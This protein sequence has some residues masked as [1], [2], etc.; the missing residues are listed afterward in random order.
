ME[1]DE[2]DSEMKEKAKKE[3][4]A[5]ED[6][7]KEERRTEE[8]AK[9]AVE[10]EKKG[11]EE[12]E[13]S[14][15]PK[16]KGR[17]TTAEAWKLHRAN[18]TGD[19]SDIRDW[20]KCDGKRRGGGL[21]DARENKV[22]VISK[23][24]ERKK[25][26]LEIMITQGFSKIIERLD[27]KK[28]DRRK[29]FK[30]LKTELSKIER[31]NAELEKK[32][33]R[34]EAENTAERTAS[35]VKWKE[36]EG[37]I[38]ESEKKM[39]K[40]MAN[41]KEEMREIK[42]KMIAEVGEENGVRASTSTYVPRT[43]EG[44]RIAEIEAW[45]E[46]KEKME[47]RNN[48]VI[49][50][51]NNKGKAERKE[52]AEFFRDELGMESIEES[53]EEVR[54]PGPDK[55]ML[56]VK[57]RRPEDKKKIMERKAKLKGKKIFI[58]NDRTKKEREEQK[59]L[60]RRA[61]VA[62]NVDEWLAEE[63]EESELIIGGDWNVRIGR[64]ASVE[65]INNRE[66]R[67]S[68]DT[69]VNR[70]RMGWIVLNGN[71]GVKEEGRWTFARGDCRTVVDY[72]VTNAKTWNEIK[73]IEIG[74]RL[75]SDHQP[76]LVELEGTR[77]SINKRKQKRREETKWVQSWKEEDVYKFEKGEEETVWKETEGEDK[78][79]ELKR[80][81]DECCVK[82]KVRVG[83]KGKEG[84]YDEQCRKLKKKLQKGGR[85]KRYAVTM[86]KLRTK[87]RDLKKRKRI[88]WE[89]KMEKELKEIK[90]ESDAWE[91]IRK[92]MR[93]RSEITNAFRIEAPPGF[94]NTVPGTGTR[95]ELNIYRERESGGR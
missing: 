10:K 71:K 65:E 66:K 42:E 45:K 92:D 54:Q 39:D 27:E 31:K 37:K 67:W 59:G 30:E 19:L 16:G 57:M 41:I 6:E 77:E 38:E 76:V 4:E 83:E 93:I 47:R 70:E 11:A 56:W 53:I 33:E 62:K 43:E 1:T 2:K 9:M 95:A 40:E 26:G 81:V 24:S 22:R 36:M 69:V 23:V 80:R 35:N 72:G 63:E 44:T 13:T 88:R 32:I 48:L 25:E 78:W 91:F 51:W 55:K 12:G 87:Y 8:E 94:Y 46:S 73:S 18:S 52:V 82:R 89:E 50:G 90:T 29:Q 7:E 34:I 15:L 75:D 60:K 5:V 17:K 74:Y 64:E 20:M 84:W 14:E 85:K 3:G 68:E 58:E 79:K 86:R 28:E 61:W 21:A 49:F